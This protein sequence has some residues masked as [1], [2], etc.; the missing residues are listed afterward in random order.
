MCSGVPPRRQGTVPAGCQGGAARSVPGPCAAHGG[1][2]SGTA[3]PQPVPTA[4]AWQ[5]PPPFLAGLA[6][7]NGMWCPQQAEVEASPWHLTPRRAFSAPAAIR[8]ALAPAAFP[9]SPGLPGPA[10]RKGQRARAKRRQ[11]AK[12]W[13]QQDPAQPRASQSPHPTAGEG[14]PWGT[15]PQCQPGAGHPPCGDPALLAAGAPRLSQ[16]HRH[17][18]H[19]ATSPVRPDGHRQPHGAPPAPWPNPTARGKHS[20][21]PQKPRQPLA[22][23]H[24]RGPG[25]ASQ[26]GHCEVL[27]KSSGPSSRGKLILLP[28]VRE[29]LT[30][31][32]CSEPRSR[33]RS[34]PQPGPEELR[35][36]RC[37]RAPTVRVTWCGERPAAQPRENTR[38]GRGQGGRR[39]ERGEEEEDEDGERAEPGARPP[40]GPSVAAAAAATAAAPVAAR[41]V[42]PR[43]APQR[44]R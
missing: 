39:Q 5:R 24:T 43:P 1:G 4:G 18:S 21:R 30:P 25:P 23:P 20:P 26:P 12:S 7:A 14:W 32:Q 40:H 38:R 19:T 42:P 11:R 35:G 6:D 3:R 36:S 13:Q 17:H 16:R 22:Q 31:P 37:R 27:P 44:P 28:A 41:R 9:G 10:E 34:W 8:R 15:Q 29:A 33:S 2:R